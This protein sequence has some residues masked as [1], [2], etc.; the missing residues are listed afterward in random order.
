MIRKK[1]VTRL[2][3][4]TMKREKEPEKNRLFFYI[5]VIVLM[6]VLSAFSFIAYQR[7]LNKTLSE[8]TWQDLDRYTNQSILLFRNM[9]DGYFRQL[10]TIGLFCGTKTGTADED[11]IAM[12]KSNNEG[13]RYTRIGVSD[14]RG[15]LYTDSEEP[16]DVSNRDFFRRAIKG[17]RVIS[18]VIK[19]GWGGRDILVLAIPIV[20]D[21]AIV[22]IVCSQYD[23]QMFT[24]L[25][26][27][28]QFA[29]IG[30]TM[31]MQRDGR[32]LSGFEGMEQYDTFYEA[33]SVMEF[34]GTDTL[35]S[36]ERR[37]RAGEH[38]FFTYYNNDKSR[39]L[40]FQPT[41]IND[42]MMIS[43]VVAESMDEQFRSI[44]AQA[45]SLMLKNVVI[46]CLILVCIWGACRIVRVLFR[47]IQKDRLTQV[48]NKVSART[49][50]EQFL[51]RQGKDRIHACFFIDIDNFKEINDHYGHGVGDQL[52]VGLT[53]QL[54]QSFR[55]TDVI[56]RF[57]GDEFLV[58][59][60]DISSRDTARAKAES[61]CTRLQEVGGVSSSVSIGVAFYPDDGLTYDAV[62]HHADQALY[63]A[64]E[65]GKNGYYVF[66]GTE[67]TRAAE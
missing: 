24:D 20:R 46:Y 2:N 60:T 34:R 4:G 15:L 17:E 30:A 41:G 5:G 42:Y 1:I 6:L 33:L 44:S 51:G 13:N 32:M 53:Q 65:N 12:L 50:M 40:C 23:V 28:S 19:N 21:G 36:L 10:E 49:I 54:V 63:R 18:Q 67:P 26:G 57:G 48:Y 27:N 66:D 29:G 25:L 22:G 58:W 31:V 39:Y 62:M 3:R 14:A 8:K 35:E 59:M 11:V 16:L 52:L 64:K 38:G 9:L 43:L 37:V 56:S 45:F 61:L 47:K 7:A 55:R